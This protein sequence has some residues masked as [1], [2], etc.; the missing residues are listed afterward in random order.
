MY[1]SKLKGLVSDL[2]GIDKRLL[3]CAKNKG[4]WLSKRGTKVSVTVLFATNF[5]GFLCARYNVSP[6]NLQSHYDGCGTLFRVN[7]TFICST[8]GLVIARHKKIR[9]ELLYPS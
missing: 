8:G 9:D 1:E 4:T 5:W 2:K 7:Y 3:I 6:L